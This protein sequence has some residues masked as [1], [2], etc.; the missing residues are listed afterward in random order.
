MVMKDDT[1]EFDI[2]IAINK[3]AITVETP[4]SSHNAAKHANNIL[5][6]AWKR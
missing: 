5:T 4:D 1:S 6:C 3:H 2:A